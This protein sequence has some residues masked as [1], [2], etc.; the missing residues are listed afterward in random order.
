M[1]WLVVLLALMFAE[2]AT[3]VIHGIL[4]HGAASQIALDAGAGR[5]RALPGSTRFVLRRRTL[6]SNSRGTCGAAR[7]DLAGFHRS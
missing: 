7:R 2:A 5:V 3:R 4:F 6:R 1:I